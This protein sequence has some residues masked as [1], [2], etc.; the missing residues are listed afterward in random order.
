MQAIITK[1]T[2]P[3]KI[4]VG[5]SLLRRRLSVGRSEKN[6]Q[7]DDIHFLGSEKSY[8]NSSQNICT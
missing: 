1:L 2:G 4:K 8:Q 3:K 7:F 5:K 6:S